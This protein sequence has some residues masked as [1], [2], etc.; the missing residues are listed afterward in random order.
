M[1]KLALVALIAMVSAR[2]ALAETHA[3]GQP[4]VL[5]MATAA[6]TGT[7]WARESV[8]FTRDVVEL[9]HGEVSMKWYFGG[10]AGDELQVAERIRRDQLD[11]TASG[12]MLCARLAPSTRVMRILGLFQSRDE[13]SYV[14]GRL[15]PTFDEE[16]RKSGYVNLGYLGVGPD[17]L[18][19]RTPVRSLAELQQAR[20]WIWELD[21]ILKLE[22]PEMGLR[23][24]PTSLEQAARAYDEGRLDVFM[25]T[26]GAALAFQWSA[27]ARYL[28]DL[29]SGFLSGCML[30]ASRSFDQLTVE[31]QHAVRVAA[32]KAIARLEDVGRSQDEALL[33]GLFVK[34]GLKEIPVSD[35]FRSQ[36][37]EA[38]RAV[39]DRLGEKLVPDPLLGR[40]LGML[41]DYRAEHRAVDGSAEHK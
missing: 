36:F 10:I 2:A 5:R 13:S 19:A 24:V 11:G 31:Q 9:T 4:I 27:Q 8:A 28:V 37:F 17:V 23:V 41:A 16:F 30:L 14:S 40:V 20:V 1:R 35:G 33:G 12:G 7:R 34:Q 21:D 22:L 18:F 29:R 32:A 38:A 6:P 25:A 39:R 26:P 15:K 3:G